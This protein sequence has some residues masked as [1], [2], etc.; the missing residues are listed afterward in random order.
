MPYLKEFSAAALLIAAVPVATV[1]AADSSTSPEHA[2]TPSAY[3]VSVSVRSAHWTLA[4]RGSADTARQTADLTTRL[5]AGPSAELR[6][7]G[8]KAYI[9]IGPGTPWLSTDPA[10]LG[11]PARA[12][13][14]AAATRHLTMKI[15]PGH[16]TTLT[17][18]V[19]AAT[20]ASRPVQ[21]PSGAVDVTGYARELR[22]LRAVA[23]KVK[24][25]GGS[26]GDLSAL[27]GLEG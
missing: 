27:V 9:H 15:G 24:L 20:T 14:A 5:P 11:I 4:A 3:A 12:L 26:S 10:A 19:T 25:T 2:P 7:V 22:E 1:T 6:F 23:T 8:G 13:W 18:N 17:V 21:T 16:A